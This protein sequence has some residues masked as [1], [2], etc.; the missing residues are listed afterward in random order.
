MITADNNTDAFTQSAS[1]LGQAS[2][3]AQSFLDPG[4]SLSNINSYIDPYYQ[5][6]LDSVLGRMQTDFNAQMQ[7]VGDAATAAGAFGGGRHGVV[8][9]VTRGEYNRNVGDVTNYISSAAYN[10]AAERSYRDLT[11]GLAALTGLGTSYFDIG[12][13]IMDTQLEQGTMEQEL[14]QSIL[15]MGSESLQTLLDNPYELIDL[16]NALLSTDA[17]NNAGSAQGEES[18]EPGL[19]DYLSLGFQAAGA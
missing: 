10:D 12:N 13:S 6:V 15:D 16:Y 2:S 18:Y 9:G 1:L 4:A 7:S 17:R 19:F 11:T 8:E 5:Q 14:L 3:T